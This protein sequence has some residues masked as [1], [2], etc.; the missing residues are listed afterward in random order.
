VSLRLLSYNIRFGGSG[1]ETALAETIQAAVPD[2]VVLQEATRPDVVERLAKRTGMPHWA[3]S[4]R[5]SVGFMS[6]LAVA[7]YEWRRPRGCSRALLE[8]EL[9][10]SG[11]MVFGIHLRAVHSEWSERRRMVE[12]NAILRDI[13]RHREGF[14]VLTGDF[15]TLAPGEKLDLARLPLRLRVVTWFLGRKIRWRTVQIMLDAGYADGFRELHPDAA[16]HTFPTWDPHLRL[17]YVFLP[18]N[19][20][21]RLRS[22][23]VIQTPGAGAASDHFP[24]LS[25]LD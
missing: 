2:I 21:K 22:C 16:G 20:T 1:R 13:A 4:R 10:E 19:S 5:H 6:R 15:N 23:A 25:E 14:H 17:D 18:K 12:L 3:A 11:A 8:L 7:R 24:L 9:A